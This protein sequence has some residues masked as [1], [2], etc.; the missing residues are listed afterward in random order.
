MHPEFWAE[1]WQLGQIGFHQ[2]RVHPDLLEL[3]GALLDGGPHGVL[4]PLC[5]KS[6]DLAHLAGLGHRVVGVELVPE[7][8]RAFFAE[9]GLCAAEAA[10][11]PFTRFTCPDLP[12]VELLCGDIFALDAAPELLVGVDRVWDRAA[13]VA[14]DAPRRAAYAALLRRR[15]PGAVVLLNS[16]DYGPDLDQGPPHSVQAAELDALFPAS[17][18]EVLRELVEPPNPGL[19]ARGVT[20][21]RTTTSRF[22]LA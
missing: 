12:G 7:A 2:D 10:A 11:G 14:L 16:F 21:L 13:L 6:L 1:R 4:V 17:P 3:G 5:G 18:R 20:G 19:A 8:V 22:T 9:R 15:L